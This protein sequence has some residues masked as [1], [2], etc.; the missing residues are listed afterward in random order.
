MELRAVLKA[1]FSSAIALIFLTGQCVYDL[2]MALGK[3]R[4]QDSLFEMKFNFQFK[5]MDEMSVCNRFTLKSFTR[6]GRE[7]SRG[8]VICTCAGLRGVQRSV[9]TLSAYF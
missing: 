7:G 2:E 4:N 1:C 9:W 6:I 8:H 3:R 5:K